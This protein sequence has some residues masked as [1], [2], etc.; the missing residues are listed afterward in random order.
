MFIMYENSIIQKGDSVSS[1]GKNSPYLW[2][3]YSSKEEC[4]LAFENQKLPEDYSKYQNTH[5][6]CIG[7]AKTQK[8]GCLCS[9]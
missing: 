9:G 4:I 8:D 6:R 1:Q 2:K 3:Y 7:K 5:S